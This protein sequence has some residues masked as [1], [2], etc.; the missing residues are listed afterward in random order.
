MRS[1]IISRMRP[2]F[3]YGTLMRRFTNAGALRLW[4]GARFVGNGR[5]P[6]R[7]YMVDRYPGFRPAI[8]PGE[9]VYGEVIMPAAPEA[10]IPELDDYEGSEYRRVE[11][12]ATLEDGTTVG[13]WLY[14]YHEELPEERRVESGRF[15]N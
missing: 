7:M 1:H 4:D 5:V 10:F 11:A 3:V 13:V 9:W 8:A 2:L 6:G 12:E 15:M 14:E